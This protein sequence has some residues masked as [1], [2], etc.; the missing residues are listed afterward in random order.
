MYCEPFCG[1]AAVYFHKDPSDREVLNDRN[2]DIVR[3]FEGVRDHPDELRDWLEKT[4]YS[5]KQF[6]D[7]REKWF[8]RGERP[9]DPVRRA[10]EYYVLMEQGY[11][12]D[13]EPSSF[14]RE[15]P[16]PNTGLVDTWQNKV[17]ERLDAAAERLRDA[18]IE[19]LDY[20]E[21]IETYD[22]PETVFYCDPPYYNRSTDYNA[23]DFSHE[24]FADAVRGI[25]ADVVVSYDE[26]PPAFR[27]LVNDAGWFVVEKDVV[28]TVINYEQTDEVK[29]R[30]L[31]NFDPTSATAGQQ[32]SEDAAA[33]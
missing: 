16:K 28:R 23:G 20:R 32:T 31:M 29:E 14:S 25:D 30:L 1:S 8:V 27:E 33:D 2:A 4:P 11:T 26:V 9:E 18:C 24:G 3:F 12:G 17:G 10:G 19:D 7:L 13:V 5:R 21:C 15:T 6:R 22:Y